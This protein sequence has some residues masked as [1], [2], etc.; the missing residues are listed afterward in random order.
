MNSD[1]ELESLK[2]HIDT[3]LKKEAVSSRTLLGR[4]AISNESVRKSSWYQDPLFIPFY[5][6]LGK[7]VKPKNLIEIGFGSGFLS[8]CFLTSCK[9]VENFLA[10]ENDSE[11]Y[12]LRLAK[13]NVKR[14]YKGI[15]NFYY[16]KVMDIAFIDSLFSCELALVHYESSLDDMRNCLDLLWENL[17]PNGL[18]AVDYLSKHEPAQEAFDTFCKIANR[19]PVFY[20][21]RY[22]M[23]IVMK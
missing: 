4:L 22:K 19:K 11:P 17:K 13:L 3:A 23:G 8:S 1:H 9:S 18:I 15:F 10:F 16:G 5:Y 12:S 2:I 7:Y 6:H 14:N 21:T 20:D